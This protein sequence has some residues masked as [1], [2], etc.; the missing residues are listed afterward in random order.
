M[1]KNH[2][3]CVSKAKKLK[4]YIENNFTEEQIHNKLCESVYSSQVSVE[5]NIVVL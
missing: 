1:K 4:K 3:Q 5:D 2:K